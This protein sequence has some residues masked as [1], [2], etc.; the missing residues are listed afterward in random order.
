VEIYA[1]LGLGAFFLLLQGIGGVTV[2]SISPDSM[3]ASGTARQIAIV[4]SGFVSGA[5]VLFEKG[6]GPAPRAS[7]V[8]VTDPSSITATVTAG[9]AGTT[10]NVRVKNPDGSSAALA[11]GFRLKK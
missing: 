9:M 1:I 5:E 4:G 11:N 7:K 6:E 3:P 2:D 8:V 10:W